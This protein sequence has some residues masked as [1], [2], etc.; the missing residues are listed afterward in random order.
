MYIPGVLTNILL[1]PAYFRKAYGSNSECVVGYYSILPTWLIK[2]PSWLLNINSG[3]DI[4][5]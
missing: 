1:M 5:L 2:F 4:Y 3:P